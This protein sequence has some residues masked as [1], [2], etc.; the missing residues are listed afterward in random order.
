MGGVCGVGGND[1]SWME[2]GGEVKKLEGEKK[3]GVRVEDLNEW[4][5]E[6]SVSVMSSQRDE[7]RGQHHGK[8]WAAMGEGDG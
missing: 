5:K 1:P 4:S 6:A 3:G 2:K 8:E 7:L